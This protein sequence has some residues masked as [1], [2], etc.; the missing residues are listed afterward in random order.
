MWHAVGETAGAGG[1]VPD[2]G[3]RNVPPR[4]CYAIRMIAAI[5]GGSLR[6]VLWCRKLGANRPPMLTVIVQFHT[7][8]DRSREAHLATASAHV[9]PQTAKVRVLERQR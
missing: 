9:V 1:E 3:A 6:A 8:D 7:C 2:L 4:T 5:T